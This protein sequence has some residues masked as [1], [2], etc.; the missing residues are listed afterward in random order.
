MDL[1]WII[2]SLVGHE[3]WEP[4]E[5]FGE[6]LVFIG[7]VLE[8]L[9]ERKLVLRKND[10]RRDS[11]ES[12]GSWVLIVGLAVS[13]AALIGANEHFNG[14]IADLN[15]K[16]SQANEHARMLDRSTQQL[17][18]EAEEAHKE[19]EAER[20]ARVQLQ[21]RV[22]WRTISPK[23]VAS[24][25][26]RL[27]KYKG[28]PRIA[29]ATL[30]DNEE[31]VSFADDIAAAVTAA[32]W[33]LLGVAPMMNGGQQRFGLR[34]TST[35]D[36]PCSTAASELAKE[37]RHFSPTLTNEDEVF[38]SPGPGIYIFVEL[39]PRTVRVS[40]EDAGHQ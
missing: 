38:N 18:T 27:R 9:C 10:A 5:Y 22:Q 40:T 19:A 14:T 26:A 16:S 39:R 4:F 31:A 34:I 17:R 15:F 28:V 21:E 3:L 23:D 13:L 32:H 37:L 36:A 6:G 8:V 2:P 12:I 25:G 11:L 7:V 1:F 24:I 33:P 30:A 29:I 35:R 20:L